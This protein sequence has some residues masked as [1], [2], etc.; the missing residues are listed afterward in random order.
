[1]PSDA[2]I[3]PDDHEAYG[4]VLD[5]PLEQLGPQE[6]IDALESAVRHICAVG[7]RQPLCDAAVAGD[8]PVYPFRGQRA[9]IA[10]GLEECCLD[11]RAELAAIAT[12]ADDV[13]EAIA[14]D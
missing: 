7:E 5:P 10:E 2:D 8:A 6:T 12:D 1:M 11:C 9:H 3:L 4:E 13:Q 14:D